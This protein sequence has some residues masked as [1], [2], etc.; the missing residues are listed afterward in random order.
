M[1]LDHQIPIRLRNVTPNR[2]TSVILI[3]YAFSSSS[4]IFCRLRML[5]PTPQ[6]PKTR[7]SASLILWLTNTTG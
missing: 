7:L 6:M 1:P 3:L 2:L 4:N 5:I